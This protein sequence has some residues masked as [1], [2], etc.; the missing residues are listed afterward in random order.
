MLGISLNFILNS[1]F[2]GILCSASSF[3]LLRASCLFS[4][5]GR[6]KITQNAKAIKAGTINPQSIATLVDIIE[7][8][9]YETAPRTERGNKFPQLP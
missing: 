2:Q 7:K 8:S 9:V 4:G 3:S 1:S 5:S 6:G